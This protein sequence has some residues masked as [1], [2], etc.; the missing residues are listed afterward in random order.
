LKEELIVLPEEWDTIFTVTVDGVHFQIKEPKNEKFKF[1]RVFF[2]HKHGSAGL[3][4]EITISIFEQR[5][6]W[7]NGPFLAGKGDLDI[8]H[9]G[10]MKKIPDGHFVIGDRGYRGEYDVIC[11]H[12]SLDGTDVT[13]FKST[14]LLPGMRPT[15]VDSRDMPF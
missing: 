13:E 9:A 10:L 2:S 7:L 1:I 15:M 11:I 6:V 12:N 4:Y 8:F 5:V 14:A 3:S